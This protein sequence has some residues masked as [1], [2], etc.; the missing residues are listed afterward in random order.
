M[1]ANI[2]GCSGSGKTTLVSKIEE[3]YPLAYSRL[4]SYTSRAQRTNEIDGKD[5]HC[6]VINER[7]IPVSF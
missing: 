6:C 5:Y 1:I 4:I 2:T 7:W 3:L